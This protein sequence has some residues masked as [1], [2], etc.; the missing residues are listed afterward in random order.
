MK[1]GMGE[2]IT[3]ENL[4]IDTIEPYLCCSSYG[5]FLDSSFSRLYSKMAGISFNVIN[6]RIK[7]AKITSA[8]AGFHLPKLDQLTKSF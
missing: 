4:I 7:W 8:S 3:Y 2:K 5:I 1:G 6:M